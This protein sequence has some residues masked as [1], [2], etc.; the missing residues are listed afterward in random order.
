MRPPIH[1][2]RMLRWVRLFKGIPTH[3]VVGRQCHLSGIYS[4]SATAS[5]RRFAM[6][7]SATTALLPLAPHLVAGV[8]AGFIL[9]TS[10]RGVFRRHLCPPRLPAL[11]APLSSSLEVEADAVLDMPACKLNPQT[12]Q[13][14]FHFEIRCV[15]KQRK[16]F[17]KSPRVTV[18]RNRATA[19]GGGCGCRCCCCC[20]NQ[21]NST[22]TA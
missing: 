22:R 10:T 6:L 19:G 5:G 3:Q 14:K 11:P 15:Y 4:C 9:G 21:F 16:F 20:A 13:V 2:G 7:A 17:L 18:T 1:S 8:A 12:I